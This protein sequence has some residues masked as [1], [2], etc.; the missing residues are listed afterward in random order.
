[1]GQE[2][3]RKA[4]VNGLNKVSLVQGNATYIVKVISE[5]SYVTEKVFVK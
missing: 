5:N 4:A 3:A 1:M 2:V